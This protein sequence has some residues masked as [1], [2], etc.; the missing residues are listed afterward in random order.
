MLMK[1][2]GIITMHKVN[3]VGSA[4]QAYATQAIIEKLGYDAFLIDYKY[5]N[6]I[7]FQ[8]GQYYF[9]ENEFTPYYFYY[10]VETQKVNP[11][12]KP[13]LRKLY[14]YIRYQRGRQKNMNDIVAQQFLLF[15]MFYKQ[16]FKCTRPYYSLADLTNNPP[17][18]D[19]FV[20]GSDQVWNPYFAKGD[21]AFL[22][23]FVHGRN[24]IAFSASFAQKE[25]DSDIKNLYKPYLQE[26]SAISLREYNG[27]SIIKELIGKDAIV[28]LDPTLLLDRQQWNNLKSEDNLG[29]YIL[30]YLLDYA[31]DPKPDIFLAANYYSRKLGVKVKYIGSIIDCEETKDFEK[32]RIYGPVEFITLIS[33]SEM[34][35]T[36]SFHGTSFAINY[37]KPL[38]AYVSTN[39]GDDRQTSLLNKVGASCSIVRV[40][41]DYTSINPFYDSSEVNRNLS[42][43]REKSILWLKNSLDDNN[44]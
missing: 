34:V 27:L 28:T 6:E 13:R 1:K 14:H 25:I 7:Q 33:N 5:P 19:I 32:I 4:L 42:Q 22:L 23:S 15:N 16:Y 8:N 20:T 40:G 35:I 29:K 11:W 38:V 39:K 43:E 44:I 30:L 2:V 17:N 9:I 31:F 18:A 10:N 3:N 21:T 24:K 12:W 41:Q 26:Y 37:L 36:S